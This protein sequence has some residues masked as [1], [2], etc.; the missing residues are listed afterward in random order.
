[1]IVEV[2]IGMGRG[3]PAAQLPSIMLLDPC[4]DHG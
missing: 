3:A 1:M 2:W 4:S